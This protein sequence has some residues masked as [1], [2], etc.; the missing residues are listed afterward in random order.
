[1]KL[2]MSI[3]GILVVLFFGQVPGYAK[4]NAEILVQTGHIRGVNAVVFSPDSTK[5]LSGDYGGI[6]RLW[7]RTTGK[8]L[9]IFKAP[10]GINELAFNPDGSQMLSGG[11][12]ALQLWDWST[13]KLIQTFDGHTRSITTVA[14]SPNGQHIISGDLGGQLRLWASDTGQLIHVL[15]GHT[16]EILAVAFSPN[17]QHIIS[18]DSTGKIRRWSNDTGKLLNVHQEF[19]VSAMAF[20]PDGQQIIFG[21]RL[22]G[23]HLGDQTAGAS[24]SL[25]GKKDS[26]SISSVRTVVFSSDSSLVLVN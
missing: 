6:V 19:S 16:S 11:G 4:D 8:L 1:M 24:S 9:R 18:G 22:G 5:I 2:R 26:S 17:G 3:I 14:F 25:F 7:D 21:D 10:A 23:L 12:K 15:K 20:S 13:G